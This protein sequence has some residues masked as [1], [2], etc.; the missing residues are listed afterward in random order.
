MKNQYRFTTPPESLRRAKLDNL[1]LVPGNLLPQKELW[2]KVANTLPEGGAL[3]VLP[4]DNPGQKQILLAVA[5]LLAQEG[6]QV[7]VI[8][9]DEVA[10]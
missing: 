2:Q 8:S 9:A 3:I 7:R 1:A 6:H 5:K 4:T 10:R